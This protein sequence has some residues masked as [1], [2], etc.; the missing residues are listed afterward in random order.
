MTK[1]CVGQ[2]VAHN[3]ILFSGNFSERQ[4]RQLF[5]RTFRFVAALSVAELLVFTFIQIS[6]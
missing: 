1:H 6:W 4:M 2:Y 5:Q 3:K